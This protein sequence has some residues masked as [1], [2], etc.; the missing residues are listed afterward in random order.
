MTDKNIVFLR[1]CRVD[2]S[3]G[4]YDVEKQKPQPLLISVEAELA[5]GARFTDAT[6]DT[7]ARTLDYGKIHAYVTKELPR[8]GHIHLVETVAETIAAF[9]LQSACVRSVTVDVSKTTIYADTRAA[10]V[11]IT[12]SLK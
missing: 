1:D 3:V 11:R 2:L 12:R 7:T 4:L 9:C 10:G 5:S 8:L 6:E